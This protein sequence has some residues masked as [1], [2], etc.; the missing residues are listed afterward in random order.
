MMSA[1][2]LLFTGVQDAPP[3]PQVVTLPT[4]AR[5]AP[6]ARTVSGPAKAAP[7]DPGSWITPQDYPALSIRNGESGVVGF[8]LDVGSDGSVKNCQV[9]ATSGS[10]TL[11]QV[12]CVLLAQRAHFTPAR[13]DLG[14]P[15]PS[16]FRS[17]IR[18]DLPTPPPPPEQPT[19]GGE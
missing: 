9:T 8:S 17:R 16:T 1:L 18:W 12:T 13:D 2:L 7:I 3:P 14:R 19:P 10:I 15:I 6:V 11:D 4:A 5:P